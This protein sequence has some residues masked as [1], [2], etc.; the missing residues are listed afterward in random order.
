MSK[1]L[2]ADC[3]H[4]Y[5]NTVLMQGSSDG[6]VIII[7]TTCVGLMSP[8]QD[9]VIVHRIAFYLLTELDGSRPIV[10]SHEKEFYLLSDFEIKLF[11]HT[12]YSPSCHI[13]NSVEDDFRSYIFLT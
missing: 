1:T 4:G 5:V 11:M 13:K 2:Q 7:I 6:A 8:T 10:K 3:Y 9:D 12:W